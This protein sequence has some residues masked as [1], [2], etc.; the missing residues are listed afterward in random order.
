MAILAHIL[1][2][3]QLLCGLQVSQGPEFWLECYQ[4]G[5]NEYTCDGG[6]L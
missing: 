1:L 3:L 2:I 5:D 4:I 6:R